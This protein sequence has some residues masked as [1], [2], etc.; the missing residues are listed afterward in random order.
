MLD[1]SAK[2]LK[3]VCVVGEEEANVYLKVKIIVVDNLYKSR[4]IEYNYL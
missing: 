1:R 4:G 2:C 3:A